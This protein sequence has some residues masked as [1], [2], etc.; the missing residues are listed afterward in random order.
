[1]PLGRSA[2][3]VIF[4]SIPSLRADIEA[5]LG[6]GVVAAGLYVP[7]DAFAFNVKA[8]TLRTWLL[9]WGQEKDRTYDGAIFE[10]AMLGHVPGK[11]G[12]G[13]FKERARGD[14]ER[15]E[16]TYLFVGVGF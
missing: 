14:R 15:D 10:V 4:P 16:L 5:G 9:V 1:V 12:L 8:A 7:T 13:R 2:P 6:G 11:I 3:D